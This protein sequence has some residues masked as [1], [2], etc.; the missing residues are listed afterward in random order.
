MIFDT[1]A[2]FGDIS[3]CQCRNCWLAIP[4]AHKYSKPVHL[5]MHVKV[6]SDGE[7]GHKQVF[8]SRCM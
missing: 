5:T 7:T 2:Y 4:Q 3:T 8:T 6:R 1:L